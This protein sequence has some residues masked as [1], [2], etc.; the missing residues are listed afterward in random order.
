NN[1]TQPYYWNDNDFG[2]YATFYNGPSLPVVG[3]SWYEA[4]A[5]AKWAGKRLPTEAEWEKAARGT[6]A[7]MYPWGNIWKYDYYCNSKENDFYLKTAPV[8][9]YENG[10]SP[11]GCYDIIGNVWEWCN[12]WY[13]DNYYSSSPASNPQGP[14]TSGTY[15]STRGG[16]WGNYA[17]DCRVPGRG[18]GSPDSQSNS[19]GFRCVK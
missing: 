16:S 2:Y 4:Y 3:V 15:R 7:R 11:Y 5:Y 18:Y 12:D 6:D 14:S 17:I 19:F 1:V 10:K 9:N 13:D 8:G